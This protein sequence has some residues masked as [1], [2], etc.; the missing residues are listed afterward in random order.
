MPE[1]QIVL[2]TGERQVGKSTLCFR[3]AQALQKKQIKVSGVLTRRSGP[4]DLE[5]LELITG[6]TYPLTLPFNPAD[7]SP[8]GLFQMDPQAFL[9]SNRALENSFPTQALFVDE[10]GPRE[11]FHNEGWVSVF[12]M[13][14]EKSY[15][16][17]F[18]VIRPELLIQAICQL[19]ASMYVLIRVERENRDF[20][21]PEMVTLAEELCQRNG[22][23]RSGAGNGERRDD[24][25]VA[26]DRT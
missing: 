18:I 8:L 24:G 25:A 20:L 22:N 9:R 3:T 4:H 1:P 11:F 6:Q 15:Q 7:S 26:S 19:P 12:T 16:V 14:R 17:A 13:L 10:L 21:C 2:I 23:S 5:V